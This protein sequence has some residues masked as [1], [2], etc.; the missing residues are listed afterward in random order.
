MKKVITYGSFDLLHSGHIS[1]LRR[2]KELGDYLVVGITSDAYD[3]ERGKLNVRDSMQT[4]I[5]NIRAT[6][7][8]DEILIE[9]FEGQKIT[10]IQKHKIDI[11][12]V[13]SD[14]KGKFDYLNEY[15]EVK[16]LERTRDLSST[17]TGEPG[18]RTLGIGAIGS[19][20]IVRRFIED[21]RYVSG[22]YFEGVYN[23]RLESAALLA[24]E[25]HL[26]F[27]TDN[28]DELF[29]R[30]D[31]I[32]IG[33]PHPSHYEYIVKAL[34]AG[35]HVLC[36]KPLCLDVHEAKHAYELA[37]KREL[38]L[39]EALK[40]AYLPA[41]EHLIIM[42]KSGRIGTI[43]DI[44]ASF[45]TLR[46]ASLRE[47]DHKQGGGSINELGSYVLLPIIKLLG[48]EYTDLSFFPQME[49]NVDIFTRGLLEY[50]HA[51]AS[52]KVGIGAKTEGD[53]VITGTKG[54][55]Y[56]PAPW[57]KTEYFELRFENPT[58]NRKYFYRF[59]GEGFRYEL[60][61][62]ISRI[63]GEVPSVQKLTADESLAISRV[64]GSFN[65]HFLS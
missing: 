35:L 26:D 12:T 56:V 31:A 24:N 5:E 23:P 41:F 52:F 65:K 46:D 13:G 8:A 36:E 64:I 7:F 6:G 21:A 3:N 47:F 62:F 42:A 40:T 39:V 17:M 18:R 38:I 59:D 11:F 43:K 37:E 27:Y 44:D 57:W 15:C 10:D 60:G 53:L 2:A 34:E 1:L 58:N 14:W 32:Y 50:P 48:E 33:T 22:A 16:Y 28:L 25:K 20:R 29:D 63:N 49:K 61:D 30:V 55:V 19:G 4:R 51:T 54:Y 9:E 45:T